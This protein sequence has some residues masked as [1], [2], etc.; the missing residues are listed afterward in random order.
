MLMWSLRLKDNPEF[1]LN[2][3]GSPRTLTEYW[4]WTD[5]SRVNLGFSIFH[6]NLWV[7]NILG[8]GLIESRL[9]SK[10]K[11]KQDG[12]FASGRI[13]I[14]SWNMLLVVFG[15]NW[16]WN[17]EFV[18]SDVVWL[19]IFEQT[20][21]SSAGAT[22]ECPVL[23]GGSIIWEP[24]RR[25]YRS[26]VRLTSGRGFDS[27]HIT[28]NKRRAAADVCLEPCPNDY[29]GFSLVWLVSLS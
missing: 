20:P 4:G 15:W 2:A 29:L 27:S 24:F 28:R 13:Q 21:L 3:L 7:K 10:G 18:M 11:R 5:S 19:L 14:K 6:T 8:D 9:E 1:I 22:S 12:R 23:G 25:W 16:F 26:P 17:H